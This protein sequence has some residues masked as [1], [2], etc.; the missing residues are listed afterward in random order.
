MMVKNAGLI[1]T[2]HHALIYQSE[3]LLPVAYDNKCSKI[4]SVV[5][6]KCCV[7]NSTTVKHT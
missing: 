1:Y 5:K 6:Q 4:Q 2:I 7:V 3:V